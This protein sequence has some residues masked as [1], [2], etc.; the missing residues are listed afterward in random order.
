MNKKIIDG[1]KIALKVT[2]EIKDKIEIMSK[3]QNIV[4]GLAVILIGENP[5]SISYV[6]GKEKAC[7]DVGIFTQTFNLDDSSSYDEVSKL[8]ISL[9]KDDRFHGILLQLPLPQHLDSD[10]L[11]NLINPKKDVD[12]LTS[13][14]AGLLLLGKPRF[15]PATPLGIQKILLEENIKIEGSKILIIGRSNLVGLPLSILLLQRGKGGNATVTIA[16][17]RTKNIEQLS[18]NAD[19]VIVASGKPNTLSGKM[20]SKNSIV[21]DVGISRLSDQTRKTGYRLIGDVNFDEVINIASKV[22]PVPGGVGPMTIAMLLN[23][24]YL[25]ATFSQKRPF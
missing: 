10:K 12:G 16:H 7:K 8:I 17:T 9:N 14:N 23:N 21:I 24:V 11:I 1:K 15:V 19:I 6:K 2:S 4:P 22:T 25:A 20:V 3:G 13:E 5:A 18:L